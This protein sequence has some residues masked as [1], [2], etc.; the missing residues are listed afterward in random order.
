MKAGL[1]KKYTNSTN[2]THNTILNVLISLQNNGR[3]KSTIE[4]T[5]KILT[6]INK[7]ANI[8]QPETVKQLIANKKCTNSYKKNMCLAYNRY[9]QHYQIQWTMPKYKPEQ[10]NI[11]IPTKQTLEMIIANSGTILAT[12][13]KIS[14]ETG[15]RPTEVI[16]LKVRDIDLEQKRIY[17]TTAKNGNP[18]TLKISTTLQNM[19]EYY[20]K[21]EKLNQNDQLFNTT[22]N[23][24]SKMYQAARNKLA[25]KLQQPA[26]RNIRLYD[27]RHHFATMLYSKTKDILYVMKQIFY[28]YIDNTLIYTQLLDINDE[29]E[30]HCKTATNIKQAIN[31]LENGFTYIQEIDGIRIYRKRK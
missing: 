3:S 17:P 21:R 28:N 26:I 24:Y 6:Y 12:K 2:P 4:Q 23:G 18:R 9:C 14:L 27:F 7:H 10:R 30:Y 8:R 20:I 5:D 13:L 16:N 25:K 31:L 29:E 1:P 15:L 11:K 19:L 22:A